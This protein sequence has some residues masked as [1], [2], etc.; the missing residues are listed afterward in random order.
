[1]IIKDYKNRN[2]SQKAYLKWKKCKN[3]RIK[4]SQTL[5]LK[6]YYFNQIPVLNKKAMLNYFILVSNLC[7]KYSQILGQIDLSQ[8]LL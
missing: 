5:I 8:K 6:F 1:M 3:K 2:L 4:A 7:G